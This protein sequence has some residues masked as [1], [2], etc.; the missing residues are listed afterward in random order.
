[1][2]AA[3]ARFLKSAYRRE[4]ITSFVV[5]VGAVDA[6]IGGLGERWSLFTIGMGTVGLA[7][8]LRWWMIH[9]STAEVPSEA[10][11]YYLPPSPSRPQLPNLSVPNRKHPP[12]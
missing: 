1:M 4:P 9:R 11:E 3:W 2:N 10:P 6:A 5:T 12:R 7:I 8:A